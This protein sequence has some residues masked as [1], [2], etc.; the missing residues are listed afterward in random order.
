[1]MSNSGKPTAEDIFWLDQA[2]R[3]APKESLDR[4]DTQAKY[5]FTLAA[6]AGTLL[7]G[8]GIVSTTSAGTP[9]PLV[10]IPI[11]L[12]ALSLAAAM[13]A[14]TPRFHVKDVDL[15]EIYSI[16]AYYEQLIRRKVRFISGAGVLF[17]L[18]LFSSPLVVA[19]R[20]KSQLPTSPTVF[21]A[22]SETAGKAKLNLK[23]DTDTVAPDTSLQ[24]VVTG[25]SPIPGRA[26]V[27]L[28][29]YDGPVAGKPSLT[30]ELD[31]TD[32]FS[33]F[34]VHYT[35]TPASGSL[36]SRTSLRLFRSPLQLVQTVAATT[37]SKPPTRQT[38]APSGTP[39][40]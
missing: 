11:G 3:L 19:R 20:T 5:L 16:R 17:A 9:S 13:M 39:N 14:I 31:R 18:A 25:S 8:F 12:L 40:P 1:M 26:A 7:T 29:N 4:L 22:L 36:S 33:T 24:L 35:L 10:L 38:P 2:P 32:E 34:D 21:A 30:I 15:T 27:P 37:P 28:A 23:I 6:S